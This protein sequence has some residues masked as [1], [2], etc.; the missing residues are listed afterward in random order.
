V[1][2]EMIAVVGVWGEGR[3]LLLQGFAGLVHPGRGVKLDL[4]FAPQPGSGAFFVCAQHCSDG[5]SRPTK[6]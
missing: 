3:G 5:K 1:R 2:E 4:S 6:H